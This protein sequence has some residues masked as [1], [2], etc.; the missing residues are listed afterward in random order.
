ME[1]AHS[2]KSERLSEHVRKVK[3]VAVRL[4]ILCVLVVIIYQRP[5]ETMIIETFSVAVGPTV[6]EYVYLIL[7]VPLGVLV[8]Y[9]AYQIYMDLSAFII[10][11][12]LSKLKMRSATPTILILNKILGVVLLFT[13]AI[14][15]LSNKLTFLSGY[16]ESVLASFSGL[17]SLLVTLIIAMQMKEVGGNFIAGIL[18]RSSDVVSEGDYIKMTD[19]YVRV[20]KTDSTYT[21]VINILGEQIFIPNLKFL[22]DNFRRPYSKQN[23]EYVDLR[24]GT[25]YTYSPERVEQDMSDLV[26]RYNQDS[27]RT[28]KIDEFVVVTVD[29]PAYS[30]M[31]ELRVKPSAPTFPEAIRSDFRRL[32]LEKY[33]EDL[34]TP[35]LLNIRK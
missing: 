27:N 1:D 24:F 3:F 30:V 5:L 18:L 35:M 2:A 12:A 19:E 7:L 10:D 26:S 25:P 32:L 11:A 17:F 23:R 9:Y 20:E 6:A 15:L 16:T 33:G 22:T 4:V 29:L 13:I 28:V 14:W 21:R 31:Y 34:A 8:A